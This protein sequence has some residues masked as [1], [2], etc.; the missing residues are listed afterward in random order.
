MEEKLI[1]IEVKASDVTKRDGTTF[2]AFKGLTKK[3][4][5]DL[6][7]K[8]E[9]L[10]VPTHSGIIYVLETNVNVNRTQKFPVIWVENVE[11]FEEFAFTQNVADYFD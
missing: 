10:N 1:K 4:W 11:K 3:G 8:K 5:C 9:C 7:F 2:V 6:K